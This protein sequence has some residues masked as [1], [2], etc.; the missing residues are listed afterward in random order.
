M[1]KIIF[2]DG[3]CAFCNKFVLFIL[4]QDVKRELRFASL[5]SEFG[6]SILSKYALKLDSFE[7]FLFLN[8]NILFNKS[9]AVLEIAKYLGGWWKTLGV[10]KIIPQHIRDAVYEFVAKNR[11]SLVKHDTSCQLPQKEWIDRFI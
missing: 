7:T 5:Q 9:S 8:K 11:H 3:D 2:Y 1:E 6:Q 4:K 10:F